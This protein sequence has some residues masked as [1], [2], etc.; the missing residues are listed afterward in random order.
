[1]ANDINWQAVEAELVH[2]IEHLQTLGLQ[3]DVVGNWL[4]LSG[5]TKPHVNVLR[6]IG[7][8]WSINKQRWFY[9]PRCLPFKRH[10]Q[11]SWPMEKIQHRFGRQARRAVK[12]TAAHSCD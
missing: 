11:Q 3:V 6:E 8:Q 4:W 7:C 2:T 12:Q 9:K 1:M 10:A 5:Q